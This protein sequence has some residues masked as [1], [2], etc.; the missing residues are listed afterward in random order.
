MLH[1]IGEPSATS[2]A[3][4]AAQRGVVRRTDT[5]L[6]RI[7]AVA[8]GICWSVLFVA[9]G[10]HYELQMYAD[11]SIFSYSVAVKDAWAF[12][13][14]SIIGRVFVYLFA[15]APAGLYLE[16]TRNARGAV[17]V[18]GFLFF[19]A[20]LL[21]LV[22]TFAADHSKGRIIFGYACL[23]TACLC[24]LV[25][26]FPT[27]I[28]IA[29]SLFWPALAVCHYTRSG[30]RGTA[31]VFAVLLALVFTHEG[32]LIFVFAILASLLLRGGLSH[33]ALRNVGKADVDIPPPLGEV[34]E[35]SEPGGGAYPDHRTSRSSHQPPPDRC[36]FAPAV[37]L[38]QRGRS[39]VRFASAVSR[40]IALLLRAARDA[41]FARAAGALVPIILLWIIARAALPPDDYV[42]DALRRAAWHVFDPYILTG[43][44]VLLLFGALASYAIAFLLLRRLAPTEA[45]IYA[46]AIVVVMLV[47]YWMWFDQALHAGNR[48]YLRTVVLI[49]TPMLGVLAAVHALDAE[50]RLRMPLPSRLMELF[51]SDG[52]ARCAAGAV[53][54]VVLVHAVETAKFIR[55]WTDYKGAVVSLAMSATSDPALG[56]PR[57]V[58]SERINPALN[59]LAWSSTTHF[60]SVLVAPGLAP[61]RLVVDPNANY[62][63][64]SCE[65]AT[66]NWDADRAVPLGSRE[67]V[68]VYAC[69]HR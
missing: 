38:P 14:H 57:F 2:S 37:D 41:T 58:S 18:Y 60:L 4:D 36:R 31:L 35:R 54:L 49:A 26:G 33:M 27:E 3:R 61:R 11:G 23:S 16:I 43:D 55:T 42:G 45:P 34:G 6:L 56:D 65:T 67:L 9:L 13:W 30:I 17:D 68:R 32:A 50:G 20:P 25:F 62:F 19:V 8:A 28:W 52:A 7:L 64:L 48:Y 47:A 29:H 12:H 10:L 21:G 51:T 1:F 24:P 63:W 39:G 22:A 66:A 15:Y 46:G 44:L 40:P 53:V 5:A 69:I 59:R